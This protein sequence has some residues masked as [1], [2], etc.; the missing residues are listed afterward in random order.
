MSNEQSITKYTVHHVKKPLL[1]LK[2][3]HPIVSVMYK[4]RRIDCLTNPSTQDFSLLKE[5]Q[6]NYNKKQRAYSAE[7]TQTKIGII[8]HVNRKIFLYEIDGIFRFENFV[9]RKATVQNMKSLTRD[10]LEY[11]KKNI[12]YQL[13]KI[14]FEDAQELLY[15]KGDIEELKI[16]TEETIVNH[17][18]TIDS[19]STNIKRR[20]GNAIFRARIVNYKELCNIFENESIVKEVLAAMCIKVKGRFVLKNKFYERSHRKRRER[21]LNKIEANKN[22]EIAETFDKTDLFFIQEI[23][24]KKNGLYRL[25]GFFEEI[26]MCEQQIEITEIFRDTGLVSLKTL[27]KE[28]DKTEEEVFKLTEQNKNVVRL[29]NNSFALKEG[30]N[31]EFRNVILDV[32]SDSTSIKKAELLSILKE[33]TGKD[34]NVFLFGKIIKEFATHKSNVYT[35]KSDAQKN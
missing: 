33:K 1:L 14:E 2:Q 22:E 18:H 29:K 34:I 9:E 12:N 27:C 19:D 35:L 32:F 8:D 24:H 25:K 17:G 26:D 10:E 15:T 28:L 7:V 20:I 31:Q 16:E 6:M 4:P 5:R 3:R 21:L 11:K 23:C 30:E 13:K